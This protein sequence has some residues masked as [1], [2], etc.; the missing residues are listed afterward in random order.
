MAELRW[1]TKGGASP[2]GK[3]RVYFTAHP[4]DYRFFDEIT[5]AITDRQNCAIFYLDP[6][7]KPEEVEDFDLRLGQMQL[8]VVPV[9]FKLLTK[10]NRAMDIDIPLALLHHIPV[11]P[12]MQESGLDE[13]FNQRFGDLQYLDKHNTDPTAISYEEKLTKYLESV[14][15]GD[16]LAAKVRAAF[17]AYIFLS[18][19]KKD[20]RYAQELMKLIHKNPLCRDIAIWY[21][22]FLTPGENFNDAIEAALKKSELF[23]LAVTPNLINEVNY[24]LTTEYP[25]AK[26]NGKEILPVEMEKT[27]RWKLKRKYKDI[28][29]PVEKDDSA[30]LEKRLSELL[31]RVAVTANDSDPQHNFFIGLAYLSGIDV[32]VDHERA[33]GL[34]TGAAKAG[35]IEAIEKLVSM[36]QNGEG[37][38]RDY[39]K[40]IEWQEL[41]VKVLTEDYEK[42]P[43]ADKGYAVLY[44]LSNLGDYLYAVRALE[45]AK[46]AYMKMSELSERLYA[47][48]GT[49]R[50]RRIL[51]VSYERLG[52]IARA[53]GRPDEAQAYYEKGLEIR[54]ALTRE[55]ATVEAKRDL[56]VS[57]ERLGNIAA[58]QGKPD[59]ARAY[60]EKSLEIHEA[61]ARETDTLEAKRDLFVSYNK[62]GDIAKAQGKPDEARAY[63]EK[64]LKISE[65][66]ARETDT[67]EAKRD[68]FVSYNRLGGVA[69]ALGRLAEARAYYEKELA[70]SEA[71]ARE[72]DTVE[73]KRDLSVSY[74]RLGD[75]AKAQGKP[76]EARAYYE[77][78]LAISEA[79]ARETDTV[80]AK[81]DLS[82]S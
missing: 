20:R 47:K 7:V 71:L 1:Y 57:Y 42:E 8:F 31:R 61:L 14:I 17:D 19:R 78:G 51:S 9:T 39:H 44:A 5:K 82:V 66:L 29:E 35:C 77:K 46:T 53:Q 59:E 6:D 74:N 69:E 12:L 49:K 76:D 26:K 50:F 33:V 52:D 10:P 68:L 16:E 60:Y 67:V 37:V 64:D 81:R 25:M 30:E 58:A 48:Y 22:E 55:T 27:W 38:Q 73:A 72:T 15:V 2:Q 28:P 75:I 56:S 54:E 40:A 45:K 13:L 70:I 11:L 63:Y 79:L 21:D 3:P 34:I 80:E 23:A 18:Y 43:D 36:Y 65:E 62:L 41:L 24:I 32:E 4:D